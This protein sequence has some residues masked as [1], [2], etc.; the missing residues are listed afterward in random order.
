MQQ[1]QQKLV[2]PTRH[3]DVLRR[4]DIS[5]GDDA[6]AK[7]SHH[8]WRE[9]REIYPK[10]AAIAVPVLAGDRVLGCLNISFIASALAPARSLAFHSRSAGRNSLIQ[11]SAPPHKSVGK[12]IEIRLAS[13][14]FTRNPSGKVQ[15]SIVRGRCFGMTTVSKPD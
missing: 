5:Q 3:R 15:R 2:W 1:L 9:G 13:P 4:C 7:P 11:Q 10:T 8:R 12:A 6:P 14:V